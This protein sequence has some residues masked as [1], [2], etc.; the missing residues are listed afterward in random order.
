MPGLHHVSDET[1]L[2]IRSQLLT[3]INKLK[4]VLN[5]KNTIL[6]AKTRVTCKTVFPCNSL[7]SGST[8]HV[9]TILLYSPQFLWWMYTHFYCFS[10]SQFK[11][12]FASSAEPARQ[13]PVKF[14]SIL[15]PHANGKHEFLDVVE[16]KSNSLT[17]LAWPYGSHFD[18]R[19]EKNNTTI[20]SP[21]SLKSGKLFVFI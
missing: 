9:Y 6:F 19:R 17:L 5:W 12:G 15:C 1:F 4:I 14:N 3:V 10:E 11:Q 8:G 21:C 2:V 7:R 16:V 13:C 20:P 18:M